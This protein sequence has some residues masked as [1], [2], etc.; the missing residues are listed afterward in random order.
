MSFQRFKAV[1][2]NWY[3]VSPRRRQIDSELYGL[4]RMPT[5]DCATF[6]NHLF[7]SILF[8][9]N[10]WIH[11]IRSSNKIQSCRWK[12]RKVCFDLFHRQKPRL[13]A[14]LLGGENKYNVMGRR[15]AL[16]CTSDSWCGGGGFEPHLRPP[17]FPSARNI[18]LILVGSRNGFER[19]FTIELW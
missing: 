9:I 18:T 2:V 4:K 12:K 16:S 8:R 19:D 11:L 17:L 1:F 5:S 14:G 3:V 6:W 13:M 15:G 7:S 10:R